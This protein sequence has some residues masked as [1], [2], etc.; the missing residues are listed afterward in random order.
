MAFA[1][2][3]FPTLGLPGALGPEEI[4]EEVWLRGWR[5]VDDEFRQAVSNADA[6]TAWRILSD[7]AE[8]QLAR[9]RRLT[10]A[11]D[12][13]LTT[14]LC[15]RGSSAGWLAGLLRPSATSRHSWRPSSGFRPSTRSLAVAASLQ[16]SS[17][18]LC[19]PW[20]TRRR[21]GLSRPASRHGRLK[22]MARWVTNSLQAESTAAQD[23]ALDPSLQAQADRSR[24]TLESSQR[25]SN[26]GGLSQGSSQRLLRSLPGN[27]PC[28]Q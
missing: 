12:G 17:V 15:V 18:R 23:F 7:F 13:R 9:G 2:S 25:C 10:S 14:R 11:S 21:D 24:E 4:S 1:G 19:W 3:L 20:R 8:Q 6:P 27:Q 28:L 22:C 5:F 16:R 26:R